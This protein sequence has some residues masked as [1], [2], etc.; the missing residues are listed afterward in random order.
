MNFSERFQDAAKLTEAGDVDGA[1][2]VYNDI[3]ENQPDEMSAV[4]VTYFG[5]VY[6]NI[7]ALEANRGN[8]KPALEAFR[9]GLDIAPGNVDA[10]ANLGIVQQK[11][12]NIDGAVSSYESAL[13]MEPAHLSSAIKLGAIFLHMGNL[14]Q[15]VSVF[16]SASKHHPSEVNLAAA[17]ASAYEK[18]GQFDDALALRQNIVDANPASFEGHFY[19]GRTFHFMQNYEGALAAYERSLALNP[20]DAPTLT[21]IGLSHWYLRDLA[22]A[23]KHFN[24]ALAVDPAFAEAA[25]H[26][27]TLH[28]EEGRMDEAQSLAEEHLAGAPNNVLLHLVIARTER[29]GGKAPDALARLQKFEGGGVPGRLGVELVLELGKAY[30]D[31]G[32]KQKAEICFNKVRE[33]AKQHPVFKTLVER[34]KA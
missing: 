23:E 3:L 24:D 20:N 13:A 30:H 15:A 12:G 31:T 27:A 17:L 19:M 22:N 11:M 8:L 7:G 18:T 16:Q 5:Q 9:A 10:M 4:H 29:V 25:G 26:L 14:P 6:N 28:F 2:A 33:L 34:I 1:L 21:N 32:D